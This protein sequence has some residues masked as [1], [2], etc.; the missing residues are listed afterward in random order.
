MV[1]GGCPHPINLLLRGPNHLI[2]GRQGD[3]AV[4]GRYQ[5]RDAVVGKKRASVALAPAARH[6]HLDPLTEP[7][8]DVVL[9]HACGP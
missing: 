2:L 1:L 4:I 5:Q 8:T 7:S 3:E 9:L 6:E